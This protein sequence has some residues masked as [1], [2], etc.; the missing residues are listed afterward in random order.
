MYWGQQ[1]GLAYGVLALQSYLLLMTVSLLAADSIRWSPFWMTIG[2][3]FVV[4][5]IV[6]VW[7]RGGGPGGRRPIFLELGYAVFL[8]AAS[9]PRS[10]R[11]CS[12]A[13]PTGT[14]F[15]ARPC[16]DSWPVAARPP[17]GNR[18]AGVDLQTD[19]YLALAWWVGFNTLIFAFL[20]LLQLL[21]P[22]G[23]RRRDTADGAGKPVTGSRGDQPPRDSTD[24]AAQKS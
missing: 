13:R 22:L 7:R 1:L 16:P 18:A 10:Y 6:T 9:S 14:T 5:R 12:D 23:R 15:R 2:M 8:Q 19:W 4:E 11:S 21:P 24:T 3:I 17:L 20:S